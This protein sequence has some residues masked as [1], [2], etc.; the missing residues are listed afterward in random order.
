MDYRLGFWILLALVVGVIVANI[1]VYVGP[2]KEKY[3]KAVIGI[4]LKE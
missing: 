4:L 2:D 1:T 3:S